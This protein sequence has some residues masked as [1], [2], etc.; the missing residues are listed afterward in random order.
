MTR[1]ENYVEAVE[2]AGYD[3]PETTGPGRYF[4]HVSDGRGWAEVSTCQ[5]LEELLE[6]VAELFQWGALQKAI[7]LDTNEELDIEVTVTA[8]VVEKASDG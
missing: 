4:Y 2:D 7:D 8:R 3:F 5:T 6:K 1:Y